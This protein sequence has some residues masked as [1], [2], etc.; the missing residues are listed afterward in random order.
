MKNKQVISAFNKI[1]PD[2][3]AKERMLSNILKQSELER[4]ANRKG[5]IM[6]N[7]IIKRLVPIAACCAA[8]LVAA[9]TIPNM[10]DL[11][12]PPQIE[13]V[14]P[15]ADSPMGIRK[16]INYNGHRYAFLENGSTYNLNKSEITKSLGELEYDITEDPQNN[17][18]KDFSATFAVGGT[19]YEISYYN[20]AFRVAVEF[21]GNYY[22]C[23]NVDAVGDKTVDVSDYFTKA[24]FVEIVDEIIIYDHFKRNALDAISDKETKQMIAGLSKSSPVVLSNDDYEK[25]GKAQKSGRSFLLSFELNDKTQY[26][27]YVIP[28]LGISMIGDNRYTLPDEFVST[29]GDLFSGLEQKGQP[30]PMS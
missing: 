21:D 6:T 30:I 7:N 11:N 27:M 16:I 22:I 8:V 24:N 26:E 29:Y 5:D 17:G 20:P 10:M 14:T 1:K 23:E 15:A 9:V 2:Q 13:V 19:V 28:T 4:V 12:K 18:T 25:I 3:V